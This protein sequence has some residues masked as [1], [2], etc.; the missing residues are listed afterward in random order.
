MN[1]TAS[2]VAQAAQAGPAAPRQV[3]ALAGAGVGLLFLAGLTL[4]DAYRLPVTGN[5]GVGPSVSMK[6]I[7]A[8]LGLLGGAHLVC[9]WRRRS[10]AMPANQVQEQVN[11]G[12][13]AWVLGG[14]IGQIGA[15][16]LGGGFILGST[17][18]FVATARAFG[19]PVKSYAP[20]YGIF[21]STL[22]YTFFTKALSLTLPAGPI[23]Q[24]F[25]G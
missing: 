8:I 13:L 7:G 3:R 15:L 11:H 16:I 19:K 9:A 10:D 1:H 14:L 21:L 18:L 5:I 25:L 24:F 17:I 2:T 22:V 6:L 20:L 12:A 4:F 23:E